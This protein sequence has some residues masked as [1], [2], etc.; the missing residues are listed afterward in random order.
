MN[1]QKN[2]TLWVRFMVKFYSIEGELDEY[3]EKELNRIGNNAFMLTS[4]YSFIT[5][6]FCFLSFDQF[7]QNH[8]ALLVS[9]NMIVYFLLIP[10]YTATAIKFS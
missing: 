5:T 10:A 8:L 6:F 7:G 1:K 2:K 4:I 3:Q 9:T